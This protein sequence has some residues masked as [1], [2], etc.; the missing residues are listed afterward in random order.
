M[1]QKTFKITGLH[2]EACTK[3]T[4]KRIKD[5]PGVA[6]AVVDLQ[7]GKAEITTDRELNVNEVRSALTDSEYDAEEYYE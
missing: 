3:L 7:S 4:T 5:I 2:C 1:D 6:D